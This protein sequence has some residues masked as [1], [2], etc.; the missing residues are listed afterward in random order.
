[1]M[2]PVQMAAKIE[3]R[4]NFGEVIQKFQSSAQKP[5][6]T[7]ERF[8]DEGALHGDRTGTHRYRRTVVLLAS[9]AS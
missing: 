6:A 4:E 9:R 1:M 7:Q 2:E 3:M 8:F 5:A